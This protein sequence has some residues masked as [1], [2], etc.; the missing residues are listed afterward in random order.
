MGS[1]ET[2]LP[3]YTAI[4]H[5]NLLR[6]PIQCIPSPKTSKLSSIRLELPP[7]SL[8][9]WAGIKNAFLPNFFD[10]SRAED[11][12]SKIATFTQEPTMSFRSSWI[13][14]KSYQRDCPHYDYLLPDLR[15]QLS[16][17]GLEK[18][19]IYTIYGLSIN[20]PFKT[21]IDATTELSINV[22]SKKLYVR[23]RLVH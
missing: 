3:L 16:L 23:V 1:Q 11:L 12:R 20:T 13:R 21:S 4:N 6:I 17:V 5:L 9:S 10:E 7:G 2:L 8:T 22:P 15:P 19:S 14:F 18:V